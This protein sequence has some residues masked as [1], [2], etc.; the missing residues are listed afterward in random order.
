MDD[1]SAGKVRYKPLYPSAKDV[2][3]TLIEHDLYRNGE[4]I[5]GG[6]IC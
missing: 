1:E 6:P 4:S 2:I 5:H 3:L